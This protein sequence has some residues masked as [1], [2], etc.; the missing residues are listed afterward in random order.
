MVVGQYGKYLGA[1]D[2]SAVFWCKNCLNMLTR[3]LVE[4]AGYKWGDA[5][6][7]IGERKTLNWDKR[8]QE[9]KEIVEKYRSTTGRGCCFCQWEQGLRWGLCFLQDQARIWGESIGFRSHLLQYFY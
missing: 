4:F 9:L 3:L 5:C 1:V 8:Q 6:Q 2:V 7:R